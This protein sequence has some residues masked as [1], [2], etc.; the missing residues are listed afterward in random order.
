[1]AWG[2]GEQGSK[3]QETPPGGD[4]LGEGELDC[5][6]DGSLPLKESMT[7][8]ILETVERGPNGQ[9]A[10]VTFRDGRNCEHLI[11]EA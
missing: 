8:R 11:F 1:M 10:T 3:Y 4:G 9:P 6:R 7:N 5:P 2:S